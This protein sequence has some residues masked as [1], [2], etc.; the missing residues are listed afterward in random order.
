MMMTITSAIFPELELTGGEILMVAERG[1]EGEIALTES[2]AVGCDYT[3][4]C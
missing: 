4:V 2:S 1:I 3:D